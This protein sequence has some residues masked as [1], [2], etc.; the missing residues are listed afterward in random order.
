MLCSYGCG[1]PALYRMKNGRACCS[2]SYNSCPVNRSKNSLSNLGHIDRNPTHKE[3]I[4]SV[5]CQYCNTLYANAG[6][7]SHELYCYLNPINKRE[8]PVCG[9]A[10]KSYNQNK[11][12][13]RKCGALIT[14]QTIA[15]GETKV[16]YRY[17]CFKHH[18][19]K[20]LV[21][22]EDLF[23]VAHHVDGDRTNN[24]PLNLLPF[25]HTHHLYIHHKEYS[26]I[27]KECVDEYLI[28][29]GGRRDK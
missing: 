7:K 2:E 14:A 26:Y 16:N 5:P 18:G 25:C 15:N 12:C 27:L 1:A 23:I 11:T 21:C 28:N 19:H 6:L 3:N 24:D 8:C 13:S 17:V 22:D 20:C 29:G 4:K 10:I 9:Q